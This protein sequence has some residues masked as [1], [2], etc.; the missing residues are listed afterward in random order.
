VE[1]G[2]NAPAGASCRRRFRFLGKERRMSER[3][4]QVAGR[5]ERYRSW[6]GLLARLNLDPAL[7]G[8]VDLSGVVQQTLY[9]AGQLLQRE[10]ENAVAPLLRRVLANNLAD[11]ARK[12]F[13]LKRDAGRER[14]LEEELQRSSIRLQALLAAEKSSPSV[15][16]ERAEE[17]ARLAAELDG[18]PEGQRRAVE[19]HYLQGCPLEEVARL[20]NRS[21]PSVA[22][23][24]HRGLEALRGRLNPPENA[25]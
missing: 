25:P 15:R 9:E 22:G 1:K 2:K 11:E 19:L 7:A 6:L 5:L 18:L 12:A 10:G 23:L 17:S 20:L 16:A 14:S 4:E 13:A 8:K 3:A 21:K 24:L